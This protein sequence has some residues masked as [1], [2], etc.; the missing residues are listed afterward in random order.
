[1]KWPDW[2]SNWYGRQTKMTEL[3]DMR[4]QTNWLL[5]L[6][7]WLDCHQLTWL[8]SWLDWLT[9]W[10]HWLAD[11]KTWCR[12]GFLLLWSFCSYLKPKDLY[13]VGLQVTLSNSHQECFLQDCLQVYC[14][15]LVLYIKASSWKH[16]IMKVSWWKHK[17]AQT[18]SLEYTLPEVLT[19]VVH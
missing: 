1:M 16:S 19:Q 14:G 15:L 5:W 9:D 12:L 2:L 8:T 6:A 18:R 11:F 17:V 4:W 7:G 13:Y 3:T 10:F